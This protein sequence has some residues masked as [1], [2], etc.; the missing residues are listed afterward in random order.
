[1][2]FRT[3]VQLSRDEPL[4]PDSDSG[5]GGLRGYGLL[6]LQKRLRPA[7]RHVPRVKHWIRS[8]VLAVATA[9]TSVLMA[10]PPRGLHV[11]ALRARPVFMAEPPV[12]T[13]HVSALRARPVFMAEP[14]VRTL[15]VS[16]LPPGA[17]ISVVVAEPPRTLHARALRPFAREL[18]LLASFSIHP[19]AL[20]SKPGW[21]GARHR[22]SLLGKW[23]VGLCS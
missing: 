2:R 21:V 1:L 17:R 12:R 20:A 23:R 16:A 4:L 11:S 13:L 14:P 22:D 3:P 10:E 7:R 18:V 6:D 15:Y 8:R 5:C 19:H 9:R